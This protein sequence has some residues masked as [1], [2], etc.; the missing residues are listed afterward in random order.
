M[1]NV[2]KSPQHR[3]HAMYLSY[4]AIENNLTYKEVK[5]LGDISR[6]NMLTDE[7]IRN[8]GRGH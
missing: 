3:L 5:S 2:A 4:L 7:Q 1:K 6:V 8:R